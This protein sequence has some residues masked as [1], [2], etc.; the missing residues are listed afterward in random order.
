MIETLNPDRKR[1]KEIIDD[2]RIES[3]G[4]VGGVLKVDGIKVVDIGVD[5][6]SH[7]M[8]IIII[9]IYNW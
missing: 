7:C 1:V 3:E 9:N 8:K 6:Q 2:G 4:K 5:F